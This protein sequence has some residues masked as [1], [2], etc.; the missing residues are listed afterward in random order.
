MN[1]SAEEVLARLE[2]Y[3][4]SGVVAPAPAAA[5]ANGNGNRRSRTTAGGR[6]LAALQGA[7]RDSLVRN[8]VFIMMTTVVTSGLGYGFWLVA[9]RS[10]PAHVVGLGAA[11]TSAITL[12]T[13]VACLGIGPA[14]IYSLPKLDDDRQWSVS[15]DAGAVAATSISVVAAVGAVVLLPFLSP[16]FQV[17]RSPSYAIALVSGS[18]LGTL[19][20]LSDSVFISQRRAARMLTRNLAT[21]ALR[22]ALLVVA[23]GV[24]A[25][26]ALVIV[27]SWTVAFV[28]GVGVSAFYLFARDG[29]HILANAASIARR[30]WDMRGHVVWQQMIGLG[31][32]FPTYLLPLIVTAR[33]SA[34]QNAYFYTAWMVGSVFFIISPAVSQSLF[35]EGSHS[36]QTVRHNAKRA[37][38]VIA[39]FLGPCIVVFLIGGGNI[40]LS[41]FGEDYREH[42]SLLLILLVL[43]AIPDAITNLYVSVCRVHGW[44]REAAALNIS[45]AVGALITTWVLLPHV[46]I[47]AVGWAWLA[48][49][50]LGTVYV[51]V[52]LIRRRRRRSEIAAS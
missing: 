22:V 5:P 29:R 6:A 49:Q 34:S 38:S 8:S 32:N 21:S 16:N 48:L 10:L 26:S 18:A 43:S 7:R 11:L 24:G 31:G 14:L 50:S 46:G 27:S 20:L 23:A 41:T 2:T 51:G 40:I 35:A 39:L 15:F 9:A 45:M 30:A 28:V 42:A 19:C 52:A 44:L 25:A 37:A 1:E 33:L 3:R 47:A 36:L 17:L 13:G 4:N 12:I